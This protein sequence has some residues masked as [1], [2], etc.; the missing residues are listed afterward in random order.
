VWLASCVALSLDSNPLPPPRFAGA[1]AAAV[2]GGAGV[3]IAISFPLNERDGAFFSHVAAMPHSPRTRCM[4]G[5][6]WSDTLYARRRGE[7]ACVLKCHAHE[8][9]TT[10]VAV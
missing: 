5:L 3:A 8:H 6:F 1:G 2:L 9:S 10:E 4:R 7:D